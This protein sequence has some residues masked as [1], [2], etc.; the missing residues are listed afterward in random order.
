MKYVTIGQILDLPR[1][2]DYPDDLVRELFDGRKRVALTTIAGSG[3]HKM[4]R[5]WVLTALMNP[6]DQRLFACE[7]ASRVLKV[8]KDIPECLVKCVKVA[9]LHARGRASD[10]AL[11]E[12][13]DD[14]RNR[15]NFY[16]HGQCV[17]YYT[18]YAPVI[19][20]AYCSSANYMHILNDHPDWHMKRCLEILEGQL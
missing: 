13:R 9:R 2:N 1:C 3:L 15:T 16:D 10:K 18:A 7:C 6:K 12:C 17:C 14:A 11:K 19:E 20:S 4:D 8:R 5:L